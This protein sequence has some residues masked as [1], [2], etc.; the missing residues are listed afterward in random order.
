MEYSKKKREEKEKKYHLIKKMR[1]EGYALR[2]IARTF[3]MT[4]EG[5][6]WILKNK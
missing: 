3:K 2:E 6:S 1:E 4:A 5:I